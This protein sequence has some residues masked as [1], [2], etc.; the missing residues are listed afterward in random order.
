MILCGLLAVL[1]LTAC[2]HS[3]EGSP[4]PAVTILPAEVGVSLTIDSESPGKWIASAPKGGLLVAYNGQISN[5][6]ASSDNRSTIS[7]LQVVWTPSK[8]LP[9]STYDSVFGPSALLQLPGLYAAGLHVRVTTQPNASTEL[10]DV[11]REVA[12]V[13]EGMLPS[14]AGRLRN[15]TST[16]IRLV[17]S[18]CASTGFESV[19]TAEGSRCFAFTLPMD[20][21]PVSVIEQSPVEAWVTRILSMTRLSPRVIA[22][23]LDMNRSQ[24]EPVASVIGVGTTRGSAI[25]SDDVAWISQHYQVHAI[26]A[27][28]PDAKKISITN[29]GGELVSS[30]QLPTEKVYADSVDTQIVGEGFHQTLKLSITVPRKAVTK[31][32]NFRAVVSIPSTMY[33][34]LDELRRMERF[35]QLRL[36]SATKHIEIERPSAVSSQHMITIEFS[37][38]SGQDTTVLEMPIHLRYQSPSEERYA[39]AVITTPELFMSCPRLTP[40]A[41]SQHDRPP[42]ESSFESW[43]LASEGTDLIVVTSAY[44]GGTVTVSVPTGYTP[45]NRI[46]SALTLSVTALGALVLVYIALSS[47]SSSP[48]VVVSS[49]WKPKQA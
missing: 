26:R 15:S 2:A 49:P 24:K 18:L 6:I 13:V 37:R 46:V 9:S 5:P 44:P 25:T 19:T 45:H 48:G 30:V 8:T 35:G 14:L 7:L 16:S 1:T 23:S 38:N 4:A 28:E 47:A 36:L 39:P 31:C 33:A 10:A 12:S 29:T 34:D 41:S 40:D 27:I 20:L 22:M 3:T 17:R 42:V 43:L 11:D 32:E 21:Y